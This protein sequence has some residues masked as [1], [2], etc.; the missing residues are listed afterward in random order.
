M[1]GPTPWA[2]TLSGIDQTTSAPSL[3]RG[4]APNETPSKY[5][6]S[7]AR[8]LAQ[9]SRNA[10]MRARPPGREHSVDIAFLHYSIVHTPILNAPLQLYSLRATTR[11]ITRICLVLARTRGFRTDGR[12]LLRCGKQPASR[13]LIRPAR[14]PPR[15]FP[16]PMDSTARSGILMTRLARPLGSARGVVLDHPTRVTEYNTS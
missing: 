14:S 13:I 7:A 12:S 1:P 3:A 4:A 2:R 8:R 16:D 9:A 5:R 6:H 10:L 15:S 11:R